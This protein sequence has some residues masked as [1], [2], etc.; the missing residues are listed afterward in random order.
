M[1]FVIMWFVFVIFV[2]FYSILWLVIYCVNKRWEHKEWLYEY[3]D[4]KYEILFKEK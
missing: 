2:M 3:I 1:D 4:K